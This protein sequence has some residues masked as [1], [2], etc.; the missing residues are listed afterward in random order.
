MYPPV[1]VDVPWEG[2]QLAGCQPGVLAFP[3]PRRA[4][5]ALQKVPWSA[6]DLEE[7]V[8]GSQDRGSDHR[9]HSAPS[10]HSLRRR[11]GVPPLRPAV[12]SWLPR[13]LLA[14]RDMPEG[15]QASSGP[16]HETDRVLAGALQ[17]L[18]PLLQMGQPD[19]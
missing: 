19:A 3:L 8:R 10:S 9:R 4:F 11:R 2:A 7:K 14:L 17:V 16:A 13:V 18:E 12:P 1:E 5:G 6:C 15:S